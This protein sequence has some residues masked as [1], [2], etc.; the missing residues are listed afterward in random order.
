MK[1][2]KLESRKQAKYQTGKPLQELAEG[3]SV[4]FFSQ[5]DNHWIPGVIV[6]RLHDRSYVIISEKGRKVVRNRI[7]VKQYHKDVHVRFPI[8]IQKVNNISRNIIIIPIGNEQ[9]CPATNI[10]YITPGP[11]GFIKT[12]Q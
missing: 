10:T 6:Q 8:I 11:I 9:D 2:I 5:R 4:L 1:I 7:D 3:S 12:K